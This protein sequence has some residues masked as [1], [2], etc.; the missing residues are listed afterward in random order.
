MI[1][2]NI[3]FNPVSL[4]GNG[5]RYWGPNI[6]IS[7][8]WIMFSPDRNDDNTRA[9]PAADAAQFEVDTQ[10]ILRQLATSPVAKPMLDAFT[11]ASHSVTIR[12]LTPNAVGKMRSG[13][14]VPDNALQTD[15]GSPGAP[16]PGSDATLW[17]Y[18][19]SVNVRGHLY[20]SDDSLLHELVHA[21]RQVRGL[22]RATTVTGWDNREELYAT[23]VTNIFASRA[24]RPTDMRGSHATVFAPMAQ[25]DDQ[26][27][28]QY[29]DE[30]LDFRTR[31]L[32]IYNILSGVQTAWNPLRI[33]ENHFWNR[34]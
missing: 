29:H 30:I 17:F 4:G 10:D 7:G 8:E 31:M 18:T 24:G 13:P 20:R 23:M 33:F 25:S 21:L 5:M 9:N 11:S 12:P 19:R 14:N 6:R 26:F 34:G 16:G 15:W 2:C 28:Q 32:D 22:W 3:N 27:R 1:R